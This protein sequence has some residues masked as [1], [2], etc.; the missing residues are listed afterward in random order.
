MIN[1]NADVAQTASTSYPSVANMSKSAETRVVDTNWLNHNA[2]YV[3]SKDHYAISIFKFPIDLLAIPTSEAVA[4]EG[5]NATAA[6]LLPTDLEIRHNYRCRICS[7]T[8]ESV[9]GMRA[10]YKSD[11]HLLRIRNS[12]SSVDTPSRTG[13]VVAGSADG[14]GEAPDSAGE[15]SDD[16][17]AA[18]DIG[19]QYIPTDGDCNIFEEGSIKKTYTTQEGLRSVFRR[20]VWH[21]LE[22]SIS[23]AVV[24]SAQ[25]QVVDSDDASEKN[26]WCTVA[27]SLETYCINQMW[28]VI[29]LRSGRFAGAVFDG[30]KVMVHKACR[31]YVTDLF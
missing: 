29:S 12:Q 14:L 28:C 2:V 16:D 21:P 13:A 31:R 19:L 9:D 6:V 24:E 1:Y 8:F 5:T 11:A 18:Q 26:P 23:N 30:D 20:S 27:K 3:K 17:T 15:S 4:D 22:F 25:G 7:V 10:H